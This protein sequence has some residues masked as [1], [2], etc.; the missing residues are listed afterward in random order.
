MHRTDSPK[1]LAAR[2]AALRAF[3]VEVVGF[4]VDIGENRGRAH[5]HDGLRRRDI[6]E[7][8]NDHGVAFSDI[9]RRQRKFDCVGAVGARD[10]I[11]SATELLET[12]FQFLDFRSQ[13]EATMAE[14]ARDGAID[15]RSEPPPL[16]GKIDELQCHSIHRE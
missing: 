15:L 7:S 6:G 4:C 8:R 9:H 10:A 1:S 13:D 5:A 12:L 2:I 16:R 3:R 14:H 11:A